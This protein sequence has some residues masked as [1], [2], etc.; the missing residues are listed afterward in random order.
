MKYNKIIKALRCNQTKEE[1]AKCPYSTG[2]TC[3][4]IKLDIDAAAA[5]EELAA[6]V[7]DKDYLI[8]RQTEEIQRLQRDVKKQK[9]KM[10]ELSGKLPK[11]GQYV[12]G[13]EISREYIGDCLVSVDYED[14]RCSVCGIVF[15]QWNIPKFDYCPNCGAKMGGT[16]E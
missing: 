6:L 1:C 3:K 11:K 4:Q 12:H 10:I 5:I 16:D 9:E 14:W 2:F 7:T 13:K 15:K 8:Q